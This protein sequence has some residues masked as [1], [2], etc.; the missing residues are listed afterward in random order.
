MTYLKYRKDNG[1][2]VGV[3]DSQPVHEDGYLIAQD[4]SY[5]PGD[6]F[7]F[8][9]VVT[10]VRDGVV[11]SSACVRQAP[12]AAY[13]LQKLTEKDNKIKNL[14]TQLQVTQEA[15]DFIILGGM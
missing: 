11:L 4:D 6:E 2:V 5:K 8:Y 7:E 13:L 15:L 9:I 14:E 12:P 1:Y 3:Y 10:E